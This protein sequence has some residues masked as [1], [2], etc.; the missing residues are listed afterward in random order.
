MLYVCPTPIGNL[1]DITLRVLDVLGQADLV[2]CE[3]TRRTRILFERHGITA[4]LVSFHEHNE[5]ERL[6]MILPFCARAGRW[7]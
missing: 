6:Q 7:R 3:D 2:A 4:R 1:A 5:E